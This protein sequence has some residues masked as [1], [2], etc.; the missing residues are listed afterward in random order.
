[1]TLVALQILAG[2]GIFLF[3]MACLES[4][5]AGL[6]GRRMKRW[7]GRATGSGLSSAGFGAMATAILQSSSMVALLVLA[8]ASAGSLPLPNAIGV[9]VG[10]NLGTTLKGWIIA[11]LG[12]KVDLSAFALPML[13]AGGIMQVIYAA[14][15]RAYHW[16]RTIAGLGLLLLGLN[17]M[18][19]SVDA[20]PGIIDITV[21]QGHHPVV[22]LLAGTLLTAVIQSSSA[23]VML[24]LSA[25]YGNLISLPE[26]GALVIGADLGTTSTTVLG[27]LYGAGIKRQLALAQ[28]VFNGVVDLGAFLFLLPVL[29]ALLGM[30]GI[31]DPLYGV[32]AF[33]SM[34]NLVGL[35]LFIPFLDGFS[36]WISGFFRGP[37]NR[38]LLM[39]EIESPVPEAALPVIRQGLLQLS[40]VA[41]L[42]NLR[43]FRIRTS[44]LDLS[45]NNRAALE[46]ASAQLVID[47]KPERVYEAL[48]EQE[49]AIIQLGNKLQ[50]AKID[51]SQSRQLEKTQEIAR[52]VV[53]GSKTMKDI[54]GDIEN[55]RN[56]RRDYP[57][58]VGWTYRQQREFV[59]SVSNDI[60]NLALSDLGSDDLEDA[61][62]DLKHR[63]NRHY[64]AMNEGVYQRSRGIREPELG[65]SVQLNVNREIRH[66]H[67]NLLKALRRLRQ[68][69]HETGQAMEQQSD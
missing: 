59:Q 45:A 14:E 67:I 17:E 33:H 31:S 64:E 20:L 47:P 1:M 55:L 7:I 26:A 58:T 24:T 57:E 25:L 19:A 8:F 54:S 21:L 53:Y 51:P 36:R 15:Q 42:N 4:G 2:L 35:A 11:G 28:L 46:E 12:I 9:I 63:I 5:I 69:N 27:S 48:R 66:A 38:L 22:Y 68:L 52:R 23:T 6:S 50:E 30:L 56:A 40:L 44:I 49:S 60:I 16:G 13:G 32:V 34:L 41:V 61:L 65:L 62:D 43:R 10:S 39:T 29:P 3:G 18:K 37:E